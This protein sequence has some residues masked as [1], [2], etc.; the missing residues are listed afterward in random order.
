VDPFG[1]VGQLLDGQFR[2]DALVGEGGFSAV[3]RGT[4][5]GLGEPIA[6]KCLKIPASVW[7]PP[8]PDLGESAPQ[9]PVLGTVLVDSFVKRFRDESRILY[10]LGQGNLNIVRCIASG[11]TLAPASG[12]LVPYMVL[13]WL[14]GR[15]LEA[16]LDARKGRGRTLAETMSLIEPVA[17]AMAHAHAM[18]VVHRD[19]SPGNVFLAKQRDGSTR[20]K[21]LDFGVA[22]VMTDDLDLGPRTQTIAQ[23]RIFSPAYAAPEQFDSRLAPPGPYSDVYAL[24]L[25]AVEVLTGRTVRQGTTLGEMMQQA[26]DPN[27]PRTPRAL[28]ASVPDAVEQVFARALSLEA[29]R[30]QKDAGE[31]WRELRGATSPSRLPLDLGTTARQA[32]PPVHVET[33]DLSAVKTT[34]RMPEPPPS[35]SQ[36]FQPPAVPPPPGAPIPA[37]SGSFAALQTTQQSATEPPGTKPTVQRP[38]VPNSPTLKQTTA[39]VSTATQRAQ[40]LVGLLVFIIV[41]AAGGVALRFWLLR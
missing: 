2:V 41:L 8:P 19:L 29:N 33:P 27:A 36:L 15:S 16:D 14:E 6:I 13:E 7:S 12:T 3:Y 38:V 37:A 40:W 34:A 22:K 26:L 28:G 31:R 18:G 4:H 21:V 10:R 11:T 35:A 9:T 39:P 30:R 23:I 25:V 20:A 17:D 32:A 24:A 1:L 5:V